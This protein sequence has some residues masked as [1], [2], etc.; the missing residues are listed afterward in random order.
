MHLHSV[1]EAELPIDSLVEDAGHE[2]PVEHQHFALAALG[3]GE[4]HLPAVHRVVHSPALA[5]EVRGHLGPGPQRQR[6]HPPGEMRQHRRYYL[7]SHTLST[8][9]ERL[10]RVSTPHAED[11]S[12]SQLPLAESQALLVIGSPDGLA[13]PARLNPNSKVILEHN[14]HPMHSVSERILY[15]HAIERHGYAEKL[16]KG[17]VG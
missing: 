8:P 10:F 7:H 5:P 14:K 16:Y 17:I 1:D 4:L 15:G 13:H 2:L 6:R 11:H 12:E 3:E 9:S